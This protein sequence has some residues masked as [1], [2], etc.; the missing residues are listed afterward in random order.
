MDQLENPKHNSANAFSIELFTD[1]TEG[2]NIKN[3]RLRDL[4]F[5]FFC[6]FKARVCKTV[7][8]IVKAQKYCIVSKVLLSSYH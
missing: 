2:I 8:R 6:F 1:L 4:K 3:D 7:V 5:L